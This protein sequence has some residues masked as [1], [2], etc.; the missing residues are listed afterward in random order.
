MIVIGAGIIGVMCALYLQRAGFRVTVLTREP[1]GEACSFGAAANYG[2]DAQFAI[3]GLLW[4]LPG[5]YLDPRHPFTARLRDAPTLVP[6]FLRHLQASEPATAAYIAAAVASLRR[7]VYGCYSALLDELGA[8]DL[9]SKRGRLFVWTTE[10]GFAQDQFALDRRRKQGIS[11][12][13][14][15]GG[16]VRELE[17]ALHPDV[18]RGAYVADAGHIA[19]PHRLVTTLARAFVERGG[20]IVQATVR[21][22]DGSRADRVDVSTDRGAYAADQI[23]VAAGVWS[24]Q[25]A[26]MAGASIPLVA[27]RGYHAMLPHPG[28]AMTISTLWQERKVII[29]PMEHGVR[30]SG[31]AEFAA[32]GAPPRHRFAARLRRTAIELLPGIDAGDATTWMGPRPVTPDYLP[33]IGRS[34]RWER[35]I[36]AF[37]HGHG[38]FHLG[39]V[40][41]ELI[42]DIALNRSPKI[43]IGPFS[44]ARFGRLASRP[45]PGGAAADRESATAR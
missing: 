19:N 9:I 43:D 45:V 16:E 34:V 32:T 27:E 23:V 35:V 2:G 25:L 22:L 4:K 20:E 37:G 10:E 3:P 28:I 5:M 26:A 7:D 14:L 38:G 41:A 31:I 44:P 33:V 36:F 21:G 12:R 17:P 29:T 40:T 13:I 24:K 1:P 6:W 8:R 39:P 15:N 11:L 30:A 42:G 18:K